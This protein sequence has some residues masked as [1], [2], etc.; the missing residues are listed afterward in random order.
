MLP[1]AYSRHWTGPIIDLDAKSVEVVNSWVR[2]SHDRHV[3]V[4]EAKI[5]AEH[6]LQDDPR[7]L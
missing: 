4:E 7:L 2:L 6:I 3:L 5:S 1:R